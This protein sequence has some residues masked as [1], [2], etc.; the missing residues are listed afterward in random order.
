MKRIFSI[1]AVVALCGAASFAQYTNV[2]ENGTTQTV[3]TAWAPGT[4]WVGN[5]TSS[6]AL[7]VIDGGVV[8]STVVYVGATSNATDNTVLVTGTGSLDVANTLA[9]GAGTNNSV[10]VTTGGSISVGDL[11]IDSG[12]S[13]N[14]N[15]GGTF[16]IATNLD[17]SVEG[18]NWN[19]DGHL[20]VGGALSG[21]AVASNTV[22]LDG[23]RDL[24]LDGGTWNTEATNL[25]VGTGN[26]ASDLAVSAGGWVVVGTGATNDFVMGA[27]GGIAVGGTNGASMLVD[28]GST[29][30]TTGGLYVGGTNA[31]LTG[32]VTIT[33]GS[34]IEARSLV[35]GNDGSEVNIENGGMLSITDEYNFDLQTNVNWVSGGT[36]SVGGELTK[37]NGLYGTGHT[38]VLDGG[39]WD[40]GGDLT[41]SGTNNTLSI[42][43]GGAVTNNDGY[44]GY[45]ASDSNTIVEVS[46]NGSTWINNGTLYIGSTNT[47]GHSVTVSS[48]G[49]VEADGLNV[50]ADNDFFLNSGGTLAVNSGFNVAAQ[51]NLVWRSG[52][53]LSVGGGALSG[54]AS[55]NL[56]VD[57]NT[58]SYTF[59][60]NGRDLTIAAG[61][62][63]NIETNGLYVGNGSSGS[64]LVVENGGWVNVG[65][66]QTNLAGGGSMLVA[67]TNGAQLV[68]AS[69]SVNVEDTLYLGQG[70][71]TGTNIILDGGTVSAGALQA[72]A[73]SL[74][75]L[76]SGGTFAIAANFDVAATP[77]F[78]WGEGGALS[79]GGALSGMETTNGVYYLAGGRDLTLDGGSWDIGSSSLVV[80]YG[81]SGS[82]LA[83]KN[84]GMLNSGTTYIGWDTNSADNSVTVSSG[85]VW[86][87]SGDLWV[88]YGGTSNSLSILSGG[89]NRVEGA[90]F[91]GTIGASD[92]MANVSGSNSLWSIGGD[93]AIGGISNSVGNELSVSAAGQVEVGGVMTLNSSNSIAL[94]SGGSIQLASRMNVLSNTDIIGA[95]TISFGTNDAVLS[96]IGDEITIAAGIVFH[97]DSSAYNTVTVTNGS[98]LV[99]GSTSNQYEN[100]DALDLFKSELA[101]DGSLDGFSD[102]SMWGGAITPGGVGIGT[103]TIPGT[104]NVLDTGDPAS[105]TVYQAQVFDTS[106][107]QLAFTG[108]NVVDLS[109]LGIDVYLPLIPTGG[110]ANI[111]TSVAGLE[112]TAFASTNIEER[113]LLYQATLQLT[114]GELNVVVTQ[115]NGSIGSTLDYAA[116]ES[117]RAGFAGMKNMVFTR[118]K[119]L[120]RNL[121]STSHAIPNEV[122]LLTSTNAPAGAMGPGDQNT[123]FDMHVWAQQY[124]GQGDYDGSG[125]ADGFT[126][127]NNGTTIGADRLV[128]EALAV[129]FNYTYARSA[130]RSAN[131]DRLDTETYWIGAYGEWVGVDGLYVDA[132]AGY[133]YSSYDSLRIAKDYKGLASYNGQAFGAYADVGQY[134]YYADNLA[135][136][137][138][139]GLHALS[140]MLDAHNEKERDGSMV[141]VD[142]VDREWVESVLGLKLRHRFDTGIGR[143][144]TTGYA[145]WT[146]DFIQDEVYSTLSSGGLT[147]VETARV[148]PDQSGVNVGL[149]YSW[150]C[151]DYME[152][153]VGYNGRFNDDYEEH[154][155]SLMLDMMF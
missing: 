32:S 71:A 153:G 106:W 58:N 28:Y 125:A 18:F 56:V 9:I 57:G 83:V 27:D 149:G 11:V 6:N 76:R 127:N 146:Y 37:S 81:G 105:N 31:A 23:G 46:D 75:D 65:E 112:N 92:N 24:T 84:G 1:A 131:R 99:D 139:M 128:G 64:D 116:T 74:L 19:E 138:Y 70:A 17:I 117:V 53:T 107:D 44:V 152:I 89:T 150:I 12:N 40:L 36:L 111:I 110:V 132:L 86:T 69:G 26:T 133:G 91:V 16:A 88:G 73:D 63:W 151:T 48:G 137:P 41:V 95:G 102:I 154:T 61:G 143:F 54:M 25:M 104:L 94:A 51:S 85:S 113:L 13:F 47:A 124:S 87:N 97:A 130:A 55:G 20:I 14:L 103:L 45:A 96:F 66:V 62:T 82:A 50:A 148:T 134:Y 123:I 100:F 98:F 142:Q 141:H 79:V 72:T 35:V 120:R 52:G 93:L 2:L 109:E 101:G 29:V 126:L 38:L 114:N 15:G 108:T 140:M 122:Y 80:G 135:L 10:T 60:G 59:L 43:N 118:T 147:G 145:E 67:S 155:G 90:A 39:S 49:W 33:N 119:Q 8:S 42:R 144:Q 78:N 5:T 136:S 7:G 30:Q 129:G 121:V 115:D 68:V 34:R 77:Q 3:T 21:M 4:V 22:Y